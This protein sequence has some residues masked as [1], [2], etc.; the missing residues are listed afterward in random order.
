MGE[1]GH[2]QS[3]DGTPTVADP[4]HR[5]RKL[6][7]ADYFVTVWMG[8]TFHQAQLERR[9]SACVELATP[10]EV[11]YGQIYVMDHVV[12]LRIGL[13]VELSGAAAAYEIGTLSFTRP[14]QRSVRP[15]P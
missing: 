1:K 12:H 10:L 6:A 3:L 5:I 13:T 7:E 11:G 14:L 8:M 9:E 15:P 2:V 4:E